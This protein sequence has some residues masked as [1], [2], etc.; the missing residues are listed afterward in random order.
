M[1]TIYV[2]WHNGSDFERVAFRG[3][4]LADAINAAHDM[5]ER[6]CAIPSGAIVGEMY[7]T[8]REGKRYSGWSW[9]HIERFSA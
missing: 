4:T 3:D 1:E 5:F 9:F 8:L 6:Y 7:R 2:T